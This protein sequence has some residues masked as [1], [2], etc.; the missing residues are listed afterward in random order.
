MKRASPP[1][2]EGKPLAPE[3]ALSAH[4]FAYE[5]LRF[6]HL[7]E[8]ADAGFRKIELWAMTPHFDVSNEA[9][10]KTLKDWLAELSLE[11]PS[12]HAPFYADLSEAREGRWLSL[13]ATD[14]DAREA[15]IDK[16]IQALRAFRPFGA[17][18]A[19]IHPSAPGSA[20][21]PDSYEALEAS[22]ERLLPVAEESN[23]VIAL[24]N[25]PSALG[26]AEPLAG[27][28]GR[29]DHPRLRIC[30][31]T[32][33]ALITE[34]QNTRSA[35]EQL[36][37]LCVATHLHDNDGRS[38]AHLIPGEGAFEWPP[39]FTTLDARGYSGTLALELRRKEEP[40]AETLAAAARAMRTLTSQIKPSP[41]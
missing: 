20:G 1:L 3:L 26:R 39:F 22:I 30:I 2:I 17:R 40:Y 34:G 6:E 23:A 12:F 28:V 33:H 27:F 4:L 29:I 13:A 18:I 38:D 10:L 21:D 41:A 11:A 8:A 31:D 7:K 25:I 15:A 5:P 35:V 24:E 16:T 36:T 9:R 19:V 37:P 32:G 14:S